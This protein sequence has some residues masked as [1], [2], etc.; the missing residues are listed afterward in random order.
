MTQEAP[1]DDT[2]RAVYG[3]FE[4]LF[5]QSNNSASSKYAA[6]QDSV[7][8]IVVDSSAYT[9]I[10]SLSDVSLSDFRIKDGRARLFRYP[11]NLDKPTLIGFPEFHKALSI[12]C[13]EDD[14][15]RFLDVKDLDW[16]TV[17]AKSRLLQPYLQVQPNHWGIALLTFTDPVMPSVILDESLSMALVEF[18]S[19]GC[20]GTSEYTRQDTSW[21]KTAEIDFWIE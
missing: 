19:W 10:R 14:Q 3:L 8:V 11:F 15:R 1:P 6:L 13:L 2:M 16:E 21:I 5:L 7:T 20:G 17:F 18:Q 4:A 9:A 12:L